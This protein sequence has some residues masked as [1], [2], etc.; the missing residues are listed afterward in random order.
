MDWSSVKRAWVFILLST[1]FTCSATCEAAPELLQPPGNGL[2]LL[3][4]DKSVDKLD[5]EMSS[6]F[7][8]G[9]FF[10]KDEHGM[11]VKKNSRGKNYQSSY[12]LP[13]TTFDIFCSLAVEQGSIQ[14][15]VGNIKFM[16][17]PDHVEIHQ[18][19]RLVKSFESKTING[20]A[21]E[22]GY[23]LDNRLVTI[24]RVYDYK[25]GMVLGTD[26]DLKFPAAIAVNILPNTVGHIGPWQWKRG[27]K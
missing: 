19:G 27:S 10:I 13:S 6:A 21:V 26:V 12:A 14:I 18:D 9:H 15:S 20:I 7:L 1:Y 5:I 25:V 2:P 11:E 4:K 23:G 8:D 3:S 16:A 24:A 17:F 22:R